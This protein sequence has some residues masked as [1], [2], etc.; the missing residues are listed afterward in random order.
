MVLDGL[1]GSVQLRSENLSST[2][3]ADVRY[4]PPSRGRPTSQYLQPDHDPGS[5][6]NDKYLEESE[7][8]L[9]ISFNF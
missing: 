2:G 9:K 3:L 5:Q 7:D 4:N 1:R 6:K 8:D